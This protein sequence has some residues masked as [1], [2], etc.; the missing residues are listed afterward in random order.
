MDII[1][2]LQNQVSNICDE[3]YKN[4][5]CKPEFIVSILYEKDTHRIALTIKHLGE[6]LTEVIFPQSEMKY[7][8]ESLEKEME[9]LYNRTM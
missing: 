3:K 4:D 7:G 2:C 8:Y 1:K 5:P 6:T 9:Y